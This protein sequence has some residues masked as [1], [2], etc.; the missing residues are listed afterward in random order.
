LDD[1]FRLLTGGSR[2]ALPRH[3]T[4]R[5]SIDWSYELLSEVEQIMLGRLSVF[6]GGWTLEAAEAVVSD[7]LSVNSQSLP[8]VHRSLITEDVLDLLTHLA[9]KSLVVVE[10]EQGAETRYRL[11]E[12]IRQYAR[13]KL[14]EAGGGEAVRGRHLAYFLKLAGQ[15]EPELTG[16]NQVAWLKRLDDELD[17]LRVALA[18]AVE[19]D[20][21]AGLQI[22]ATP[23]RFWEARGLVRE[24]SGWLAQLL[25]RPMSS[26]AARA[27]ALAA[28][29]RCLFEVG[30]LVQARAL[31]EHGLELSRAESDRQAQAL[32]LFILGSVILVQGDIVSGRALVEESLALH[33]ALGDKL[34]QADALLMLSLDHRNEALVWAVSEESLRLFRELG[35]LAGIGGILGRMAQQAYWSGD[36]SSPVKWLEEALAIQRQLGSKGGEAFILQHHG[37]LAFWQGD[38]EQG[39]TYFEESI[40]LSEEVG[41]HTNGPWAQTFLAHIALRQG[42]AAQA[43]EGFEDCLRQFHKAGVTIGVVFAIEGLASLSVTQGQ[44]ERAA[45][46]LAWAD[47]TRESL[48]DRRPAVEQADVDRDLNAIR[49]RLDEAALRAAQAEGPALTMEQAIA[50]ALEQ[51]H[52]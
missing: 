47:A 5:A 36:L 4:L 13:E 22:A 41:R 48:G 51:I 43:R 27:K 46:L 24:Q 10:R 33:R 8:T 16:P 30:D 23:W 49:A 52:A 45:R 37:T 15:T 17:N 20:A 50:Y 25:G 12:T 21:E 9:N 42:D 7:Q 44:F 32:N 29:A 28:Q 26:G 35:H 1:R 6:A 40:V 3:Q 34:G 11:L 18:W 38:Y 14:V 19:T 39:R 31:A 2:T